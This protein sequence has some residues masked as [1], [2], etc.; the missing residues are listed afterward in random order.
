MLCAVLLAGCTLGPDF[1]RPAAPDVP[2]YTR[3]EQVEGTEIAQGISQRFAHGTALQS[4]WWRL[5]R[6]PALDA[7]VEQA[8]AGNPTLQAAEASLRVAQ[9]NLR[10]GDAVFYPQLTAGSSVERE[11]NAPVQQG[12]SAGGTVFSLRTLSASVSYPLDVFGGERRTVERLGAL[13]DVQR[14]AR[15]AA[16]LTLT[17]NVVNAC[18]AH[19]AYQAQ[20][21]AMEALVALETEQLRGI[22]AQ[23]RTGTVPYANL[24]SQRSLIAGNQAL[25]A[26][27]RQKS[28]QAAHLLAQL[29][30]QPPTRSAPPAIAFASL[31]LPAELPLSVPS[32]LARQRPDILASEAQLPA[33]SADI[34]VTT[35]ALYPSFS[36]NATYGTASNSLSGLFGAAGRFWSVGPT[37]L[38]PLLDGGRLRAQRQAA[39]D[40]FDATEANYRQTVLAAFAQVADVLKALEHDA[41]ALQALAASE[42]DAR[43]ALSLLQS[44][45]RAGLTPYVDVQAAD[46]QFHTASIATL[47]AAAQR[48]QDTVALFAALGGGWWNP[49]DASRKD[50]LP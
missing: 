10:A 36:L 49:S 26:P 12:S 30:G 46:A 2:R 3:E 18:I 29:Q 6:S 21:R 19:A 44:S 33:A 4:D 9:D 50:A 5:F 40:A 32:E 45:Y 11:R 20:I 8:L 7:A 41:Q 47:Q 42:Q 24:L 35:A 25:L 34:G 14:Q 23:V 22:E 39:R 15:R 16:F 31:V 43:E 28:S 1:V 38:A 48:Y 17:A 27:L 37:L 13:V